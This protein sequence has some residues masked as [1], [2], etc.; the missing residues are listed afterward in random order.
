MGDNMKKA[1]HPDHVWHWWSTKTDE[2]MILSAILPEIAKCDLQFFEELSS[3]GQGTVYRAKWK[4]RKKI[5]A[6]KTL[7]V[8]EKEVSITVP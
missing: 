1:H 4:S 5:V 7:L 3:G 2:I 6:V 8:L